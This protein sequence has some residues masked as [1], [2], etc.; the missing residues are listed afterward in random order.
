[1]VGDP[2]VTSS[3]GGGL[4]RGIPVGRIVAIEVSPTSVL[5][6]AIV[7]PLVQ[8][9]HLD[10]VQVILGQP[11][12]LGMVSRLGTAARGARWL[13]SPATLAAALF[14]ALLALAQT[15]VLP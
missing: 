7:A 9:E 8:P 11:P 6:Q 3:L 14:L 12:G 2:V 5:R 1:M 10:V 4:P 13:P 15:S